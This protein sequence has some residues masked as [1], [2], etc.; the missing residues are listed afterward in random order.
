MR[1]NRT[2]FILLGMLEL[3]PSHGY[4]LRQRIDESVGQ[5]W[6]ESWGQLYPTLRSLLSEG[7]I[8]EVEPGEE[9]TDMPRGRQSRVY[10]ITDA[11]RAA[12]AEWLAGDATPSVKRDELLLRTFFAH[13]GD[14]ASLRRNIEASRDRVR[15]AL[16]R[17]EASQRMIAASETYLDRLDWWAMTARH[18]ELQ[19]RAHLQWCDEALA[20]LDGGGE[21]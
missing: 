9:G 15:L 17:V 7:L 21:R 18:G 3:G 20:L 13:N 14:P 5:F 12:L 11:G 6:Q 10:C 2:R 19:L 8:E 16:A 1:E 4:G